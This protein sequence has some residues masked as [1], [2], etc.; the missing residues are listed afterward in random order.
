[1]RRTM[2]AVTALVATATVGAPL[3]SAQT[4]TEDSAVAIGAQGGVVVAMVINAR[5][6]PS[7]ENPTG[8]VE[9][10]YGGGLGPTY[11]ADVTCLNVTGK[12]AVIGFV[13]TVQQAG[14]VD[15]AAGLIRVTDGG[16]PG[17]GQDLFEQ[18]SLPTTLPP[19]CSSFPGGGFVLPVFSTPPNDIVVTDAQ[20]FPTTKDQCNDG[21][22]TTYGVFKNQGDCVSFVATGGKNPPRNTTG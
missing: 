20:P 6:G 1:M 14:E 17:S 22:W 11:S 5:S 9:F 3:A 15:P 4:P 21:G 8:V 18:V 10:H 12:T 16:G 19:D 2:L 13:G 7:G